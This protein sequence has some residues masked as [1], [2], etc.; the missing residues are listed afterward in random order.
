MER[1]LEKNIVKLCCGR[2]GRKPR[3]DW[4]LPKL[5]GLGKRIGVLPGD[6][7]TVGYVQV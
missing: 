4:V 7:G 2:L 1:N 6:S 3:E 5:Q